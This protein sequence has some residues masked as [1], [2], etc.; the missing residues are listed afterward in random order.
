MKDTFTYYYDKKG[1]RYNSYNKKV[2]VTIVAEYGINQYDIDKQ[3]SLHPDIEWLIQQDLEEL[4][5]VFDE[6]GN[7]INL[8]E[9]NSIN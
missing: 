9:P 2:T 6:F 7:D 4:I 1:N 8:V 5:P 3:K